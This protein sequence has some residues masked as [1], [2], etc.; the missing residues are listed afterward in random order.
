MKRSPRRA[1]RTKGSPLTAPTFPGSRPRRRNCYSFPVRWV[2]R[3]G[4]VLAIVLAIWLLKTTVLAPDP[5]E[6]RLATVERGTVEDTITNSRAGTVKARRRAKVSPEVGGQIRRRHFIEGDRVQ[7]G[8]VILELDT[9]SQDAG[10]TLRAREA[11]AARAEEKRACLAAD[12]ARREMERVEKLAADQIVSL[13]LLDGAESAYSTATAACESARAQTA[14]ARAAV[15]LARTDIE[16][17]IVRSP[18]DGIIAEITVEVGEWTTPSPPG[19]PIPAV[20]DVIDPSSIYIS[21][22]MDEVDSARIAV[23]QKVRA[24]IDS[25]R[26]REFAAQITR[27]APYVL[28][29]QEQNRTVEVEAELEDSEFASTLLP[30]TSADLEV[31]LETRDN[32]LRIPTAAL[33]EGNKALVFNED[34]LEER[35]LETGI[36]N[37]NF[38]EVASGLEEGERVVVNLD[39]TG[40]VDGAEAVLASDVEP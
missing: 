2:G 35:A 37:W 26:G 36:R 20:L 39:Q 40:M 18:F 14:R 28:D 7:A 5:V 22:P 16:K 1:N 33:M 10:L 11:D 23:G 21:A 19:M 29:I 8:D 17:T 25:H 9:R 4:I 12:R 27:V 3:I 24:T 38:T 32:I 13:D 6:V 15:D 30:G 34:H 31:I